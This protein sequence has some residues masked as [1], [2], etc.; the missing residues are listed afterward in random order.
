[1]MTWRAR[2]VSPTG[3]GEA[4]R[5]LCGTYGPA[6]EENDASCVQLASRVADPSNG[7]R[8]C[9]PFI[10]P[11]FSP[12]TLRVKGRDGRDAEEG[13]IAGAPFETCRWAVGLTFHTVPASVAQRGAVCDVA[14]CC[15]DQLSSAHP[16]EM[17]VDG[18]TKKTEK[19]EKA[20]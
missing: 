8:L 13:D 18:G 16:C 4:A 9:F 2:A 19:D 6:K 5:Q 11:S 14:R 7:T 3:S 1:M 12:G 20:R 15:F 10:P 17:V